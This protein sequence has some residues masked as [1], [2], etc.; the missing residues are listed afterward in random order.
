MFKDCTK[1]KTKFD[2]DS[3]DTD[4]YK[5]I[6]VPSPTHCPDCRQQ[7]RTAW[8]NDQNYYRNQCDLCKKKI[9]SIYSPDKQI[10]VLCSE[11]FW[12][13]KFDPLEHGRDFDFDRPFFEQFNEMRAKIPRI[14]IYNTQ[15]ENSEFTVHS[16]KNR[17]C[18][19]ASSLVNDEDVCYSD[20][21][22]ESKDCLDLLFCTKME[23]CYECI[24]SQECFNSDHLKVC[25]NLA[26]SFMCFDCRNG[27][28]L[29]G[30]V[31]LRNK[32]DCILNEP[33]SKEECEEIKKKLKTDP[34]FFT[35]FHEKFKQLELRTPKRFAWIINGENSFGDHISNV[36]NTHF[37]FNCKNIED[38]K[39][40]YEAKDCKDVYDITRTIGELL[41][42][43]QGIVDLLYSI[44]CNLTYQ[45]GNM[46]YSDNC[47][48]CHFCFGGTSLKQHQYC[49][50]NKKYSKEEYESLLPRIIEHM[51]KTGEWGEF[52]PI[53]LSPFGYNETKAQ[54]FF[55]LTKQEAL[56]KGYRWS[57]Y[58]DPP[59]Q[60]EKTIDPEEIPS[61]IE[62]VS[63]DIL[64]WALICEVSKKPFKII[65]SELK[66][67]RQKGLPIPHTSPKERHNKR[68]ATKKDRKLWD[69]N[70]KKC[71]K[72]IHTTYD[73]NKDNIVYCK[74]CYL[75]EV[76]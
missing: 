43:C 53:K 16:S 75:A 28:N 23:R 65:P 32:N 50:L 47:Q 35:E 7:R 6:D 19:M 73:P 51:K 52:F 18:Y 12:S 38:G 8:R 44:A 46:L 54:E 37:G 76:Y 31:S 62:K 2:V 42:E 57:E 40:A 67:Y 56:A 11:C 22:M 33:K 60:V 41:Y 5:K 4:F 69:S 13:D 49:I 17:N 74:K 61:N 36:K 30:C 64:N 21:V 24:D 58:G 39:F 68:M 1:C 55:P 63:D 10:P 3:K 15:S 71:G 48:S 26:D 34:A 66:F 70:C 20:W 25:V 29:I 72:A 14:A 9:I 59:P 45:S 27:Q